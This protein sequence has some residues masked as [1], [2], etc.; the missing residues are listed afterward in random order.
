MHRYTILD[1]F[2][3]Y[4]KYICS[5]HLFDSVLFVYFQDFYENL[6]MF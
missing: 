4:D 3:E 2:P 1:D 5:S 6:M